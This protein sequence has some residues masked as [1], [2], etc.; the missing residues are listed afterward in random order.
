MSKKS[1]RLWSQNVCV[2]PWSKNAYVLSSLL[3]CFII[4]GTTHKKTF[5]SESVDLL[6]TVFNVD[7]LTALVSDVEVL[8]SREVIFAPLVG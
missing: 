1:T 8:T 6:T 7:E 5:V 4:T 3:L 2:E